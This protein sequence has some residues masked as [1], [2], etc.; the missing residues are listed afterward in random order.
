MDLNG[1]LVDYDT[2]LWSFTSVSVSE[3]DTD[4]WIMI[5][6]YDVSNSL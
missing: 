5:H 2:L 1:L 6:Y 3:I 4:T